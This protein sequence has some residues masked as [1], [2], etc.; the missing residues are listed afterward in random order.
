MNPLIS[1][2]LLAAFGCV[3]SMGHAVAAEPAETSPPASLLPV[4]LTLDKPGFVTAVIERADGRRV[5]NL[6]SEVKAQAGALTLNW[7]LYDCP[8]S[9][10]ATPTSLASA[11]G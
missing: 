4:T 10:S 2:C 9:R 8:I 5:G 11:T 7:D 3:L 6:V 1:T